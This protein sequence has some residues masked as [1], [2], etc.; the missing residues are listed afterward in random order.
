MR[1]DSKRKSLLYDLGFLAHSQ[2]AVF[3]K[4]RTLQLLVSSDDNENKNSLFSF[5]LSYVFT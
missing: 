1:T 3:W 5:N 4:A 2:V